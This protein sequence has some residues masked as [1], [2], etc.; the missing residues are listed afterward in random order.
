MSEVNQ[1]FG[2]RAAAYAHFR[3]A[4]PAELFAWLAAHS[5]GDQRALDIACGSGQASLPLRDHFKQVIA[6][7]SSLK[8][9]QADPALAQVERLVAD[10]EQLPLA[11]ASIDLAVVAQGL[12]WFATPTFFAEMKRLLRPGGL[13]CAWCYSLGRITPRID[14]LIDHLHAERLQ[15]YWP[16]GR[17]SVDNHYRD[18]QPPFQR[19]RL[20]ALSI[21]AQWTLAQLLGYLRTWSAVQRWERQH[22][23]DPVADIAAALSEAW[24]DGDQ[25]RR[26]S[27]PLHFVAGYPSGQ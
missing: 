16:P 17:E 12:H 26:V 7:D 2:E 1:L 19:I 23:R 6:C 24:G 14:E 21:H 22:G 4:Y 8:Q 20:P 13:F 11:A 9:L 15:G 3:P 5:T 10:A 27:W 25:P 18:L